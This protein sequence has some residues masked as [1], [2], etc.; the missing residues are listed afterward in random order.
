MVLLISP[1]H[2]LTCTSQ[3]FADKL[4]SYCLDLPTLDGY[5]HWNYDAANSSLS[6]AFTAPPAKPDG[7][8]AWA[9][10]PT[11]TGMAG[12]QALI[13]VK[14]E[15]DSV[16]VQTYKISSYSSIVPSKLSFEVWNLSAHAKGAEI[17][18]FATVKVPEKAK[19]VNHLWQVGPGINQENGFLLKHDMT[20]ENLGSVGTLL[21]EREERERER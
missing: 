6:I 9:I 17:T 8:V 19:T 18:I 20:P 5:L 10:N 2:S 12:A 11:G 3:T 13:A 7:W 14:Q 21:R 16:S 4:Y 1:A 15:N